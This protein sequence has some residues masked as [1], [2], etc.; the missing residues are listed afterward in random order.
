MSPRPPLSRAETPGVELAAIATTSEANR[1]AALADFGAA[2][3]L[4]FQVVD[5]ILDCTQASETLGKTAGKDLD[6][7]KP[8]YVSILGLIEAGGGHAEYIPSREDCGKR[9]ATL[10][11]PGDRVVIMGARDDTLSAFARGILE[12]LG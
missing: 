4:A 12:S 2:I 9:I 3:G 10:A 11:G 1:A 5:D 8:T 6:H 7:N